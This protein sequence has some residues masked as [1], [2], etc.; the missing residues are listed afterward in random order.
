MQEKTLS[1]QKT[2]TS[3]IYTTEVGSGYQIQGG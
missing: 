3:N 1:K 2:R